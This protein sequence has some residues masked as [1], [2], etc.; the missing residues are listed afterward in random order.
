MKSVIFNAD[1]FGSTSKAN[2]AILRAHIEGILT[3]TSLMI[4]EPFAHHAIQIAREHPTLA[5]GLH[6]TVS[7]GV[8]ATSST[9]SPTIVGAEGR[10]QDDPARCGIKYFFSRSARNEIEGEVTA[11]FEKFAAVGLP[12]SH[13]D[14]HQ[15]LHMHPVVWDAMIHNCEVHG[16]RRIRIPYEEW[17]PVSPGKHVGLRVEWLFFRAL[18]SRCLK[19]LVGKGFFVADRVY[20]HL[21]TGK[22]TGEYLR[23]LLSR[24]EGRSNE[25]Y[26]HPGTPHAHQLAG[27]GEMDVELDA[28]IDPKTRETLEELGIRRCTYADMEMK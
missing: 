10:F 1:D 16:I 4:N 15:H 2:H 8:A 22:M 18:R 28:L 6:L 5:V 25:I 19:S 24:V 20:G 3:S 17:R 11:Q 27:H 14:G 21:E 26:F 12:W 7:N 9:Q 23:S 13:V